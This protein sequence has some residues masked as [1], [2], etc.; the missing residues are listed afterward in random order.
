M[1]TR[2]PEHLQDFPVTIDIPVAWGEMDSLQHVNNIVYFRYFESVRMAYFERIRYMEYMEETGLGP[3]LAATQ[4][5]FKRPL[6]YPDTV[7]VGTRVPQVE[8]G[9]FTMEFRIVSHQQQAVAAVGEGVIVSYDYRK[10]EKAP[11]PEV[12]RKRILKLE[13]K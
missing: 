4:A 13:S 11:L 12:I 8:E 5:K 7:T 10:L 2:T 3:I 1:N 9:R 6:T